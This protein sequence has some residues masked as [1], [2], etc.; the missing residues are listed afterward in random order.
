MSLAIQSDN[1]G[2]GTVLGMT[3]LQPYVTVYDRFHGKIGFAPSD[4]CSEN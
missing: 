3:F 4:N 2:F 1:S